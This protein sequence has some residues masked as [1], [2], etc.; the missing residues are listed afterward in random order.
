M[1]YFHNSFSE[2]QIPYI[3]ASRRSVA[4]CCF[5]VTLKKVLL[6]IHLFYLFQLVLGSQHSGAFEEDY[7]ASSNDLDSNQQES[8]H[9]S[10]L[11]TT[12]EGE[13]DDVDGIDAKC[14]VCEKQCND[15]EQ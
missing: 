4:A 8:T 15:I 14:I 2:S 3:T 7:N 1:I 10:R 6:T 9:E 11:D 13:E 5:D 12:N